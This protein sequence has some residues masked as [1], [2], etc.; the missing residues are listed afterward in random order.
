MALISGR[1]WAGQLTLKIPVTQEGIYRIT[2]DELGYYGQ[3]Y[4]ID[5]K[6]I[7]PSQIHIY[8]RD[9]DVA[10]YVYGEEDGKFD[11][12]DYI[13]FYGV[14]IQ[15]GEPE[16][17][18]TDENVYWLKVNA[19]TTLRMQTWEISNNG[20][21][22]PSFLNTYHAES[23]WVYWETMPN[24]TGSDGERL[25]HWFWGQKILNGESRDYGGSYLYLSNIAQTSQPATVRVYLHGKTDDSTSPDHRTRISLNGTYLGD[26][27]WDG[28]KPITYS[29][30][31][32]SHSILIPGKNTIRVEEIENPEVTVDSIFVN[33]VE[34]DYYKTFVAEGNS[35]KFTARGNGLLSFSISNFSNATIQVFDVSNPLKVR[36]LTNPTVSYSNNTYTVKFTDTVSG[37][38]TYLATAG[39]S[40]IKDL[41]SMFQLTVPSLQSTD[42]DAD[43][44][45][46]THEDLKDSVLPLVHHRENQGYRVKVVTT[47][48]IYDSFSGG[49]FTPEAIKDFLKY[50][51]E[52]WEKP[53][54]EFVLLVGDANVDY[55]N[56]WKTGEINYVP[57]YLVD[58][59]IVG[60]TPS[61]HWYVTVSGDDPLPDMLIG[62]IPAKTVNDV[63]VVINKIIEYETGSK[64]D[65]RYRALFAANDEDPR[66]EEYAD[67]WVTHLP[68]NYIPSKVYA[69]AYAD[70]NQPRVDLINGL[71][72]GALITSFFGHGSIDFWLAETFYPFLTSEDAGLLS[73]Q[74]KYPFVAAFNCLNGLFAEPA[75]GKEFT[76]PDG[77][78]LSY[79]IPLSEAMLFQDRRGALAMW[80][81]A[82]FA[83][84]SE[85]RWVGHELYSGL[86]DQGNNILGSV[87][88]M[89]KVNAFIKKGIYVENLDV[90]TFFGDPATRIPL[91]I[92]KSNTSGDN[93]GSGGGG[94]F[95]ATAAYGSYLHPYVQILRTFRD[96]LLLP[97][98]L[99][100]RFVDIYYNISPPAAKWISERP[101]AKGVT[102]AFLLPIISLAWL[103]VEAPGWTWGILLAVSILCY[104]HLVLR[105]R[106]L[107]LTSFLFIL[108]LISQI[109]TVS[110]STAS[111]IGSDLRLIHS[112][113]RGITMELVLPSYKVVKAPS[114]QAI[115]NRIEVEDYGF[116]REV[117][118]PELPL[119]GTLIAIPEDS[120]ITLKAT[121]GDYETKS[122]QIAPASPTRDGSPALTPPDNGVYKKNAYYPGPLAVPGFTGYMR[123]QKVMQILFYPVQ[124]NPVTGEV[125]IYKNIRL[126]VD[127][128]QPAQVLQ[129]GLNRNDNES[130]SRTSNTGAYKKLMK[131]M[132]LNYPPSPP[133]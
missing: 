12:G 129:K 97:T 67:E 17:K 103:T 96:R 106:L 9:Q 23:N 113:E 107:R 51:Y 111:E 31:N 1:V 102:Q 11:Q 45:I 131:D 127:F 132:I 55:K 42:N 73:N 121:P 66:F 70:K 58:T 116:L 22:E 68:G 5:P 13:E 54:P 4:G 69:A 56:Y 123:D 38:A 32:V 112:D 101:W 92:K 133:Q 61:D 126:H 18:Y 19:S 35:L 108:I 122:L 49:I 100:R 2:Y 79:A 63:N 94:C 104:L 6:N 114:R 89:A 86:F 25:D 46:I 44:I 88:T 98:T 84:P 81:P 41:T 3:P 16:Y 124:Y 43:Y 71:N 40:A 33:W 78:I 39:N 59:A 99:G 109:S 117:G 74:G 60:E 28:Q 130:S 64:S 27:V 75:E 57:A 90:F 48:E 62:R 34:V 87:T 115:Y 91:E 47:R 26:V 7:A 14:P 15:P 77:T 128:G 119:L 83:Y 80:S 10:I 120:N 125:R 52:N 53:A 93:G 105:R 65:W 118:K 30:D 21:P 8:N 36:R 110:E 95:I 37:A 85:Q 29:F 20:T 82:A 76:L 50:S 24:G 72:D